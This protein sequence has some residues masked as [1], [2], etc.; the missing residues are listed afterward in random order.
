MGIG[1]TAISIFCAA[2]MVVCRVKGVSWTRTALAAILGILSLY[3]SFGI[4]LELR[5]QHLM[6][7]SP[8][9]GQS[10][11]DILA[12]AILVAPAA[13]TL[14]VLVFLWST[15]IRKAN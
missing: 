12:F 14:V 3:L 1:I 2:I 5:T 11:M 9:D 8:N 6:K 15:R 4:A 7:V 10:A 13:S